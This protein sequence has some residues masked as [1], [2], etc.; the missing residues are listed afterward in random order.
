MTTRPTT[1][2]VLPGSP[3][4]KALL[5][6]IW[7]Y[8]APHEWNVTAADI[9]NAL[10]VSTQTVANAISRAGWSSRIRTNR[11]GATAYNL[12]LIGDMQRE[13]QEIAADLRADLS[14]QV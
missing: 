1:G 5:F 14:W 7:Q 4:T 13:E 10:G 11:Y 6:R 2:R 3:K 9:A 8:A 12:G